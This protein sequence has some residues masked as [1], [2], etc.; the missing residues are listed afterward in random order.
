MIVL[1]PLYL[2]LQYHLIRL[3]GG[4]PEIHI[5]IGANRVNGKHPQIHLLIQ[6]H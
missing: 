4:G 6:H 3:F 2:Q 1:L 5:R